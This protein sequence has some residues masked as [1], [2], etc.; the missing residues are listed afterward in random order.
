MLLNAL[1]N[2]RILSQ[3]RRNPSVAGF[4]DFALSSPCFDRSIWVSKEDI[5]VGNI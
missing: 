3:S 2:K 4:S 1:A 5:P